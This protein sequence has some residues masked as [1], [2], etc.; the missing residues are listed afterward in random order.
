[1]IGDPTFWFDITRMAVIFGLGL[2]VSLE[3]TVVRYSHIAIWH[4][5]GE[6]VYVV[7]YRA[8]MM[9]AVSRVAAVLFVAFELH[10]RFGAGF[11]WR[12]PAAV[13][14]ATTSAASTLMTARSRI[15][16]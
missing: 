6:D 9:R 1:M 8:Q 7:P 13:L 11:S 14:I 12:L 4:P 5:N 16:G 2:A 10:D 15:A 3:V